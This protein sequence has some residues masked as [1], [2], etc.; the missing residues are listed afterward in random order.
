M[1][2]ATANYPGIPYKTN[3]FIN[4]TITPDEIDKAAIDAQNINK[5]A[6]LKSN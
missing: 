4:G 6:N 1:C 3:F 2:L 5:S